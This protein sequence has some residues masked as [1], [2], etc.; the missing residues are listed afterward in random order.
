MN[1]LV[2]IQV[3]RRHRQ[4]EIIRY[5]LD[6]INCNSHVEIPSGVLCQKESYGKET[7]QIFINSISYNFPSPQYCLPIY[8]C[9]RTLV[10][11]AIVMKQARFC[12][13]SIRS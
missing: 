6:N 9:K 12:Q 10:C 8:H 7:V 1:L 13:S 3:T 11:F 5:M 2:L 4:E